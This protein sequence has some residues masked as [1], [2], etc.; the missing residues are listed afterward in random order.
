MAFVMVSGKDVEICDLIGVPFEYGGRGPETYDCYGLLIEMFKRCGQD[1]P[2]YGSSSH[3][4][5]II[6]MMLGR[7]QEWREVG[8]EPGVAI[9]IKMPQSMHV[10]FM[11]PYKKFIHTS[12]ITGG[13]TVENIRIWK[14]RI[15]GYYELR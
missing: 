8:C 1:I 2:D 7:L 13:V 11:L 4:T 12:V 3:G 9:L 15:R 10:G 14:H 5:E 6:A